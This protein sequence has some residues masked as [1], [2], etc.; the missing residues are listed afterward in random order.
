M[1]LHMTQEILNIEPP[2]SMNGPR[3]LLEKFDILKLQKV[4]YVLFGI[5]QICYIVIFN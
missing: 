1:S 3:P 2:I 5:I 4:N